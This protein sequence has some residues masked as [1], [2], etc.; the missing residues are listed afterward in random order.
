MATKT[1]FSISKDNIIFSSPEFRNVLESSLDF[2]S[3]QV[4]TPEELASKIQK[5]IYAVVEENPITGEIQFKVNCNNP[6]CFMIIPLSHRVYIP[7]YFLNSFYD[8]K[9]NPLR[10]LPEI[11]NKNIEYMVS[12]GARQLSAIFIMNCTMLQLGRALPSIYDGFSKNKH[13]EL[14]RSSLGMCSI[15]RVSSKSILTRT[16]TNAT[17]SVKQ[18]SIAPSLASIEMELARKLKNLL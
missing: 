14:V 13:K 3:E 18:F 16:I 2:S 17:Q 15:G 7:I 11:S 12:L 1:G 10:L 9:Q 5:F 8:R 4:F 6:L